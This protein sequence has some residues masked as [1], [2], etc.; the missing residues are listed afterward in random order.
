MLMCP[1][2][3]R[4]FEQLSSRYRRLILLLLKRGAVE[5]VDDAIARTEREGNAEI[6]LVHTH[7]PKL[8]EFGYVEWNR[9]TR[10]LSK[11]PHF[12]EIE[13]LIELIEENHEELPYDR[14][15]L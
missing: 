12:E 8:A 13:P 4:A 9:D 7:L 15:V 11:G 3:D 14:I 5:T 1:E 2:V 6:A 10:A